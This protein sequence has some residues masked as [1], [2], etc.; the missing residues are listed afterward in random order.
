MTTTADI[1]SIAADIARE[2]ARLAN[3]DIGD[4][5][6][7]TTHTET[8]ITTTEQWTEIEFAELLSKGYDHVAIQTMD[9]HARR[10]AA[11][12]VVAD[13]VRRTLVVAPT[14]ERIRATP[15][16][17]G[18][19]HIDPESVPSVF[20]LDEGFEVMPTVTGDHEPGEPT[21]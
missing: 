11:S 16:Y 15:A 1:D 5:P 13:I 18:P 14:V 6:M 7:P 10:V 8:L 12:Q 17:T 21:T 19:Q 20:N 2:A 3:H 4:Q 9:E